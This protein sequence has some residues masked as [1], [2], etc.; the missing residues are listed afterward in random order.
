ML[1]NL[2][3]AGEESRQALNEACVNGTFNA[4]Y[5]NGPSCMAKAKVTGK[6]SLWTLVRCHKPCQPCHSRSGMLQS[7]RRLCAP[8]LGRS[9][10]RVSCLGRTWALELL[11]IQWRRERPK[12]Q[13]LEI[14]CVPGLLLCDA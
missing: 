10:E 11:A 8:R 1:L 2:C 13:C 3:L 12:L 14:W 6:G 4:E 9:R 5:Y 7:S